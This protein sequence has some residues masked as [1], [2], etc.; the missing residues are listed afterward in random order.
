MNVGGNTSCVVLQIDNNDPVLLDLGT[1]LRYYGEHLRSRRDEA[2]TVAPFRGTA[3][4]THLHWDHVQGVPFFVPLLQEGAE[5]TVVG[6]PQDGSSLREEFCS[7]VKPPLFPVG[8]DVLPGTI[9]FVEAA[10]ST[11]DVDGATV[12]VRPVAHVGETNGYRVDSATGGSVAYIPDHQQPPDDAGFVGKS[13]LELAGG[14]DVLIHDAQYD[15]DEFAEK[16]TWGHSTIDYA[17]EVAAQAEVGTLVLFHHDP[18][19][20]DAWVGRA[21]ERAT[22]L[23]RGRFDVIVG[24]EGLTVTTNAPAM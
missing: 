6:P 23:A 3:L 8:L 21:G 17:V 10:S 4:V 1:G 19:H 15:N 24:A 9:E 22:E 2:A 16:A 18:S 12:M 14:V 13:V 20:D 5:L 11:I 7:F